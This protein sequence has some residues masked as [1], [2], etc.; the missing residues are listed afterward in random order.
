MLKRLLALT[1]LLPALAHA[2]P[3]GKLLQDVQKRLVDAPVIR[4]EFVQERQLVGVK[5]TLT[6]SGHFVVE[7]KRGVVW[8]TVKP[9]DQRLQVARDEIVQ[10]DGK[11][12]LMKL[13]ADKEPVV[14]TVG[15]VLFSLFSGDL[16]GLAK[17]FDVKGDARG[18]RWN[19]VLSP[20]DAGMAKLIGNLKLAGD[21]SIEQVEMNAAS[22]DVTRI[23][24]SK[25]TT[26]T[27]MSAEDEADFD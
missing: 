1:L 26:S 20:K 3:D 22:G 27:Q 18:A 13:T 23:R 16:S 15:G 14:R 7:K 10:K 2:D 19:L 21:K 9:F 5:K 12:T 24:M 6:A 11:E 17:H 4:G 25:V 8:H